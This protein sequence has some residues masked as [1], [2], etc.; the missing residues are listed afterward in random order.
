[1][2]A[3]AQTKVPIIGDQVFALAR[4]VQRNYQLRQ[5]DTIE[6]IALNYCRRGCPGRLSAVAGQADQCIGRGQQVE[7][8]ALQ[9][10]ACGQI[11]DI[12]EWPLSPRRCDTLGNLP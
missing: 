6:Q 2:G 9:S 10:G 11:G 7:I 1:V 4:R 12:V 3:Q 8:A 5:T